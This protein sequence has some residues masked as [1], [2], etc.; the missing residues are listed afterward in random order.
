MGDGF[1]RIRRRVKSNT[2]LKSA[3]NALA[4]ALLIGA[5]LMFLDKRKI[6]EFNIAVFLSTLGAGALITLLVSFFIYRMNDTTLA[7]ELDGEL[8]LNEKVQTMVAF[9]DESGDVIDI[10]RSDADERLRSA[11]KIHVYKRGRLTSAISF[12]VSACILTS[13]LVLI[14]KKADAAPPDPT[15]NMTEYEKNQ[16]KNLIEYVERSNADEREKK[17]ILDSLNS[18]AEFLDDTV[19][20][21]DKKSRVINSITVAN[22]AVEKVNFLEKIAADAKSKNLAGVLRFTDALGNLRASADPDK[23]IAESFAAIETNLSPVREEFKGTDAF[24]NMNNFISQLGAAITNVKN[25][26]VTTAGNNAL[27]ES[28]TRFCEEI[29]SYCSGSEPSQAILE[30]Q[31]DMFFFGTPPYTDAF[32]AQ[33]EQ[34]IIKQVYNA[35]RQENVNLTVGNYV[36]DK[37]VEMFNIPVEMLPSDVQDSIENNKK[38]NDNE[39]KDDEK[40]D[41]LYEGDDGGYGEG[42]LLLGGNDTMYFPE[43]EKIAPYGD[44]IAMYQNKILAMIENGQITDPV[45]IDYFENYF[46]ILFGSKK[47]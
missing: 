45:I 34:L 17:E 16:L 23:G 33:L 11:E 3:L 29:R 31:F 20:E 36:V 42:N 7:R 43:L 9:K 27:I 14:P 24:S 10:Q 18:L 15:Y 22:D 39:D 21:S 19:K 35:L 46:G 28:L 8:G 30:E 6:F 1:K 37:L 41:K 2:L 26:N 13:V 25:E 4:V 5:V 32:A 40:D 38:P 12:A 44:G 47:N